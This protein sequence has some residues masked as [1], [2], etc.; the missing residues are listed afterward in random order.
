MKFV[1]LLSLLLIVSSY[2]ILNAQPKYISYKS[3]Y[4]VNAPEGI[5]A[6]QIA[7][8]K[9]IYLAK[10][11]DGAKYDKQ[12]IRSV[13]VMNHSKD[14]FFVVATLGNGKTV[15]FYIDVLKQT[16]NQARLELDGNLQL[17]F[18]D[19]NTSDFVLLDKQEFY[20]QALNAKYFK[21]TY[22]L[23]HPLSGKVFYYKINN[24]EV[25]GKANPVYKVKFANGGQE[26]FN[27]NQAYQTLADD[28]FLSSINAQ[29]NSVFSNNFW[30]KE[31]KGFKDMPYN[32]QLLKKDDSYKFGIHIAFNNKIEYKADDLS[33][34]FKKINKKFHV[35]IAI[36]NATRAKGIKIKDANNLAGLKN[37]RF[38]DHNK[39]AF[40]TLRADFLSYNLGA[41]NFLNKTPTVYVHPDQKNLFVFF[42][43]EVDQT[44][45]FDLY[46]LAKNKIK[47][48]KK[49]E[50]DELKGLVHDV[51][52]KFVILYNKSVVAYNENI[53]IKNWQGRKNA[54]QATMGLFL[55]A[56]RYSNNDKNLSLALAGRNLCRNHIF[57]ALLAADVYPLIAK[58]N[59]S[60]HSEMIDYIYELQSYADSS[61]TKDKFI[62][63][64]KVFYSLDSKINLLRVAAINID[65][66][67]LT[68]AEMKRYNSILKDLRSQVNSVKTSNRRLIGVK[69]QL[70]GSTVYIESKFK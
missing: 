31:V 60:S 66:N 53:A 29:V 56:A 65:V 40:V 28:L 57:N 42:Y 59:F 58:S 11:L 54:F 50:K 47:D 39:E 48:I 6:S 18:P 38:I 8:Q 35:E 2:G 5:N 49:I 15:R 4:G 61:K 37:F 51:D 7:R 32:L 9:A 55:D 19:K 68:N 23:E 30:I 10:L 24:F 44:V 1:K 20:N 63:N 69:R 14:E 70:L 3:L 21:K 27:S 64:L 36:P 34:S 45:D 12:L 17:I 62:A 46:D 33:V 25:I 43:Q 22:P 41:A 67:K 16:I 52:N 13:I 26:I